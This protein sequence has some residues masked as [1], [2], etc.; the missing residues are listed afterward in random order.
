MA[1][2]TM[3]FDDS[4]ARSELG[5][6]SRPYREGLAEA[7]EWFIAGRLH[8]AAAHDAGR[9]APQAAASSRCL[10]NWKNSTPSRRRRFIICGERSISPTMEAIFGTRK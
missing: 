2:Y 3:H 5:Y 8:E 6:T 7:I 4:K 9:L 1:R 10:R